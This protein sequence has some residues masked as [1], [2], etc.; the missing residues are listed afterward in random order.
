MTDLDIYLSF[1]DMIILQLIAI[2][3]ND[4]AKD[5]Q[6]MIALTLEDLAAAPEDVKQYV[7]RRLLGVASL[8]AERSDPAIDSSCLVD[9]SEREAVDL[10]KGCALRTRIV[11]ESIVRQGPEFSLRVIGMD[12]EAPAGPYVAHGQ[13]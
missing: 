4:K 8:E 9:L 2:I 5:N 6:M 7:I 1:F 10:C 3:R 11:L 12:I 13:A